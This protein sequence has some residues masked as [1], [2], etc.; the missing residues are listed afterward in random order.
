VD[1]EWVD[2]EWVGPAWAVLASADEVRVA[3]L[4]LD[5]ASVLVPA[6]DA[7]KVVPAAFPMAG[8][9]AVRKGV[10]KEVPVAVIVVVPK[11]DLAAATMDLTVVRMGAALVAATVDRIVDPRVTVVAKTMKRSRV[12]SPM[13]RLKMLLPGHAPQRL[14]E[15]FEFDL[16]RASAGLHLFEYVRGGE[17]RDFTGDVEP[18]LQVRQ[19]SLLK[20]QIPPNRGPAERDAIA[21]GC[22][23]LPHQGAVV[24]ESRSSRGRMLRLVEVFEFLEDVHIQQIATFGRN[25]SDRPLSADGLKRRMQFF[26]AGRR[27]DSPRFQQSRAGHGMGINPPFGEYAPNQA[28]PLL[29]L[30]AKVIVHGIDRLIPDKFPVHRRNKQGI[31]NDRGAARGERIAEDTATGKGT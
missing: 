19:N 14:G 1:P 22:S 31:L 16:F 5:P 27:V 17:N 2:P 12:F 4:V 21:A 26:I 23:F 30:D 11:V 9:V 13:S 10:L 3:V 6:A 7:L 28:N 29:A 15:G 20:R 8:Q 25:H 18:G 24:P